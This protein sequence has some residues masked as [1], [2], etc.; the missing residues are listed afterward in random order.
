MRKKD[1]IAVK[2]MANKTNLKIAGIAVIIALAFLFLG[3][4][5]F[6]QT[7]VV[8]KT[9]TQTVDVCDLSDCPAVDCN[10]P[11]CDTQVET[12]T[13]TITPKDY[14]NDAW[15]YVLDNWDEEDFDD[16][17]EECDGE[18]YDLDEIDWEIDDNFKYIVQDYDNN[19]YKLV[20][21]VNGEY[22]NE[23]ENNF[24]IEV[25]Y[26]KSRDPEYTITLI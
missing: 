12:Q 2:T 19:K 15:T 21:W 5:A 3:S 11:V 16:D 24:K 4:Y 17:M 6:P 23:C 7:K 20:F 14:V 25:E 22:D 13:E 10:C 26:Y 8:T 9:V 1:Y 18:Y